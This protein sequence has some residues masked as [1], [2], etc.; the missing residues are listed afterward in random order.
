MYRSGKDGAM[1]SLYIKC[2]MMPDEAWRVGRGLVDR[3]TES[4]QLPHVHSMCMALC[5]KRVT[6]C[7]AL[8]RSAPAARATEAECSPRRQHLPEASTIFKPTL[9]HLNPKPLPP[10]LPRV[11]AAVHII[12]TTILFI[13]CLSATTSVPRM[14]LHHASLWTLDL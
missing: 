13:L 1:S 8:V 4:R 14:R 11:L 7:S 2:G 10:S 3:R 5:G 9:A 6:N 12:M